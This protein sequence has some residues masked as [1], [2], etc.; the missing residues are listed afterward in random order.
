MG[1]PAFYNLGDLVATGA[2]TAVDVEHLED[3]AIQI[4]GT[5]VGTVAIEI[6]MDGTNFTAL[7]APLAAATAPVVAPVAIRCKQVRA[8]VT[9]FTSGTIQV[10][11][12]GTDEDT[13]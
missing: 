13:R 3:F 11:A 6:S 5:F 9:A 2:G 10:R 4:G 7:P 12:A 8:N 1:R